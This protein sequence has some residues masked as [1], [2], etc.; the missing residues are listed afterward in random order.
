MKPSPA[1]KAG[2]TPTI[3]EPPIMGRPIKNHWQ[4]HLYSYA[5][6]CRDQQAFTDE[7]RAKMKA[8]CLKFGYT[9]VECLSVAKDP[10]GFI[11]TGRLAA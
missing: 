1:T 10:I 3:E 4:T 5:Y 11:R 7:S 9:E 8:K 6:F 2:Q